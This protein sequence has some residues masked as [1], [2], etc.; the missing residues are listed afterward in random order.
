MASGVLVE[1]GRP[2]ES[3]LA[4]HPYSKAEQKHRV[5]GKKVTLNRMAMPPQSTMRVEQPYAAHAEAANAATIVTCG[6]ALREP[7]TR[8]SR[9]H[10][11]LHLMRVQGHNLSGG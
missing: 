1:Q 2:I 8:A 9:Q 3:W 5:C 11:L 4:P 10:R 7:V 6:Q